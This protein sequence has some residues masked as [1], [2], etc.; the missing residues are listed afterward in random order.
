[1]KSVAKTIEEYIN[2]LPGDRAAQITQVRRTIL[3]NL[4]D[5]Y[6]EVINW[7]MITYQVPLSIYLDTYNK[8]PLM[9]A[10]LASQKNHMAI[11]LSGIY[12]FESKQKAFHE[13]YKE[14]GKRM[15]IGK[16]CV[17]FRKLDDLPLDLIGRTIASLSLSAFVEH[18][19]QIQSSGK[20][21]TK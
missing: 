19:K 14:T 21:R 11:Y 7:G 1:M 18:V 17:R 4:P 3:D 20:R 15:D 16:S 2:G 12:M 9:Y 10:A 6:E 8:Q 5:G 13:A